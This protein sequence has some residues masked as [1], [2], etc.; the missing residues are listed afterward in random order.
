MTVQE[1]LT[2]HH[3]YRSEV[4]ISPLQWS[5]TLAQ[6]A[7]GWANHLA[8][9][10]QLVHSH[11]GPGENL[12]MGTAGAY[13]STQMVSSWGNEKAHFIP[14]NFPNVSRTGNWR[15]VGHYTQMVWR[16]TTEVGCALANDGQNDYLVCHY[17]QAGNI[18]GQKV[19]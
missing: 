1:L 3:N 6:S 11:G 9:I 13:S 4:G 7:Q 2:A 5:A 16:N 10:H 17:K 12:W 8:S 18:I 15:D 19:Y 14:G